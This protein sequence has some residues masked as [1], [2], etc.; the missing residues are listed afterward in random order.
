M[1]KYI[2]A[3]K[4]LSVLVVEDDHFQQTALVHMINRLHIHDVETA[5]DGIFALEILSN[6]NVD[7]IICDLSMPN[8]D[9]L[10]LIREL[11][12]QNF[13][14]SVL[15]SSAMDRSLIRSATNMINTYGL[16]LLGAINKPAEPKTLLK[17]LLSHYQIKKNK[18]NE[19]LSIKLTHNEIEQAI[20]NQDLV[21]FFQP[22]I[23]MET[24]N[25]ISV[26]SLVRLKHPKY[27]VLSPIAFLDAIEENNMMAELTEIMYLTSIN[28]MAKLP[29]TL[30]HLNLSINISA[31]SL[32]NNIVEYLLLNLETDHIMQQRKIT[33]EIT[34]Q[35]CIAE[36]KS[37]IEILSRLRMRGFDLAVDDFGTGYS[38][39][40]QISQF[41]FNEMKIDR[42]FVSKM[43]SEESA[44]IIVESCILL[45]KN[46]GL[47]I[48]AEGVE[49]IHQWK[50]LKELRCDVAQGYFISKPVPIENLHIVNEKWQKQFQTLASINPRQ[51]DSLA[52]TIQGL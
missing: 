44:Y 17:Y 30:K 41:P 7:I 39:M 28:S 42:A 27:G 5:S 37:A 24:G 47:R 11:S 18:L 10:A 32:N 19:N 25:I 26:E 49:N 38:T 22:Q 45:A 48:V 43:D 52:N 23:C 51:F 13:T 1:E 50:L 29:V 9:G 8:M 20:K 34:E 21:P 31:S 33:L 16:K 12:E 40:E 35:V 4:K 14:G 2:R 46:L 36:Y 15:L 3:L 6:R